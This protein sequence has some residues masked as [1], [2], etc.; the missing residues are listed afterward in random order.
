MSIL[1]PKYDF[2]SSTKLDRHL[3]P[4][5]IFL[6]LTIIESNFVLGGIDADR[7]VA[8]QVEVLPL[9]WTKPVSVRK[10]IP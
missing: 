9:A 5:V 1:V 8:R 3:C 4:G 7:K 6:E 10:G 2:K